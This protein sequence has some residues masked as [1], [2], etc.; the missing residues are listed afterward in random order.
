MQK[1]QGYDEAQAFTGEFETLEAGGYICKIKQAV[2]GVSNK[3]SEM[4]SILFDIAEGEHAGYYQRMYDNAK[5]TDAEPKWKGVFKQNTS[6]K[7]V[8]FFK[9]MITAIEQSNPGFK[10]NWDETQL[11]GKVFG[12]VFGREQFR[13]SAGALKWTTKCQS[14]RSADAIRKG[15]EAPADKYLEG[16][17]GAGAASQF[18]EL[19]ENDP[20]LPF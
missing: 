5:K 11:K 17:A 14:I 4:M 6:G 15:V 2:M 8:S 18:T 9:G 20:D 3:G 13:N 19:T 1:P 7:S 10:W 16:A 12:G